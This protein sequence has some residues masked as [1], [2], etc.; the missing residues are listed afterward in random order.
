MAISAWLVD[1]FT[2]PYGCEEERN[3]RRDAIDSEFRFVSFSITIY[4]FF[5]SNLLGIFFFPPW[6]PLIYNVHM[7]T[8]PFLSTYSSLPCYY[9]LFPPCFVILTQVFGFLA[10]VSR[11]EE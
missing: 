2:F 5:L 8:S 6:H 1:A 4:D 3:G 10:L 9:I 11:I 7:Q